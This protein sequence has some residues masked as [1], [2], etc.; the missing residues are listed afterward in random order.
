[1]YK[2]ENAHLI[3]L[4]QTDD[5]LHGKTFFKGSQNGS[6]NHKCNVMRQSETVFSTVTVSQLPISKYTF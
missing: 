4:N 6:S 1:M 3:L 5:K 2:G